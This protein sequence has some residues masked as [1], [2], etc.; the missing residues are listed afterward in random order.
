[1]L[2]ISGSHDESLRSI[3]GYFRGRFNSILCKP[4]PCHE[5]TDTARIRGKSH[6]IRKWI[7]EK[8]QY[9]LLGLRF[10]DIGELLSSHKS[11][12][13]FDT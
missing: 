2:Y 8:G 3:W 4:C 5:E 7:E 11:S 1:V 10:H 6:C 13:D 12:G 9:V